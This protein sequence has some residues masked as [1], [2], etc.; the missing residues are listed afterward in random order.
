MEMAKHSRRGV[1]IG[2]R[3]IYIQVSTTPFF[4]LPTLQNVGNND[5]VMDHCEDVYKKHSGRGR[6]LTNISRVPTTCQ[7]L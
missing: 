6:K 5:N 4:L 3:K 2:D 7:Y 1:R